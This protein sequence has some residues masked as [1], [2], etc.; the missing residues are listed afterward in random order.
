MI[1]IKKNNSP[2]IF[3]NWKSGNPGKTYKDMGSDKK[4]SVAKR[5]LRDSLFKE[6]KGICCFCGCGLYTGGKK[7]K[8]RIAHI[9]PQ[10]VAPN[11]SMDYDNM[12]LSCDSGAYGCDTC[13]REQKHSILPI[14]PLQRDCMSFFAIHDNGELYPSK[15]AD[16]TQEK[17]ADD[18]INILNLNCQAL[19]TQRMRIW[20]DFCNKVN[21][22]GNKATA[23]DRALSR[24]AC[25]PNGLYTPFFFVPFIF[26]GKSLP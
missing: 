12:C 24:L 7:R 3:E 4:S 26:L 6:Q 1:Y 22:A 17:K 16:E 20:K 2:E 18:T 13:D 14:T 21:A 23:I 9:V 8:T 15:K 25:P 5:E 11:K 10:S 19:Q